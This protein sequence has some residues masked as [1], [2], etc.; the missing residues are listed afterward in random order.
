MKVRHPAKK[1]AGEI[2]R[3]VERFEGTFNRS[4]QVSLQQ[5]NIIA[6][7]MLPGLLPKMS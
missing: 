2:E 6:G 4:I 1:M 5:V 3:N 7:R